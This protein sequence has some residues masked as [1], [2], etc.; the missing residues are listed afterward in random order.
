MEPIIGDASA[1]GDAVKDATI[2]SFMTDVVE[3]S[4]E[5]PV[6]LDLWAPWC[7]PCKQLGPVIESAVRATNGKV[8][9]VKLNVDEAPDIAQQLRVQSIPAVFAFRNGQ[10]V[11][12]FVGALPESQIKAFV[13]K[14][15]KESDGEGNGIEEARLQA[16]AAFDAGE[17]ATAK[18]ICNEILKHDAA[19]LPTIGLLAHCHVNDGELAEAHELLDAL[20][21]D[22]RDVPEVAG[23]FA[24]LHLAEQAGSV[25]GDAADLEARLEAN[26][27]DHQARYDLALVRYG[28]GDRDGAVDAL[29]TII[30]RD[31]G[32]NEDAARTKLL[33]LF[34]AFGADDDA[35]LAGRRRLSSILFS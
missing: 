32:W 5:V 27:D 18:T 17:T 30:E 9:L 7:G 29:L 19:H 1:G 26:A 16:K 22:S 11:D 10:P 20:E 33:E 3:A 6:V 28:A 8:K 14:L 35:T 31:R 13:D 2:E 25:S 12:G 24:A 23:A 21:D 15:A 4:A 34:D